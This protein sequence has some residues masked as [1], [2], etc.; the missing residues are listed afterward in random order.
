MRL[1][2]FDVVLS[3]Q[4]DIPVMVDFMTADGTATVADEDYM[5]NSG[6][7]TFPP[8]STPGAQTQTV[9]VQVVGDRK[10]ELDEVFQML[11]SNIQAGGRDVTFLMEG[12]VNG[13]E[14]EATI[15]NDDQ[16][17]VSI[18]DVSMFEGDSGQ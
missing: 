17:T 2:M 13:A 3:N 6:T 9:S 12:G 5:S 15:E 18:D 1:M 10:V 7:V 16:A 4:V 14:A 11:L 8:S